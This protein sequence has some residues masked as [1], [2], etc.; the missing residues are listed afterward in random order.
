[1]RLQFGLEPLDLLIASREHLIELLLLLPLRTKQR[2]QRI[3]IKGVQIRQRSA[4]HGRS[5]PSI[6]L[7]IIHKMCMNTEESA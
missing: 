6:K 4:I 7:K 5:M 1:M 2:Q 3:A